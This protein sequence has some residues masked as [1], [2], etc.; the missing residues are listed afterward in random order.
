M[1]S[2]QKWSSFTTCTSCSSVVLTECHA[3]QSN[4]R[5]ETQ[6]AVA[7]SMDTASISSQ[8]LPIFICCLFIDVCVSL[9]TLNMLQVI[10]AHRTDT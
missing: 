7:G 9:A 3:P 10:L 5:E 1:T 6:E 8:I 2:K 4:V